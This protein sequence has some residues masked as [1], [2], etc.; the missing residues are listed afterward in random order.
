MYFE[1]ILLQLLIRMNE[2]DI[3]IP[4]E[5]S[6]LNNNKFI[7]KTAVFFEYAPVS[8]WIEDFS[9]VKQRADFIEKTHNQDIKSYISNNPEELDELANLVKIIDVN[10]AALKLYNAKSKKE[11]LTNLDKVFTKKSH[12]G[13]AKLVIDILLGKKETEIETVNKTFD[14]KEIDILIKFKV[15]DGTEKTLNHVIISVEN[16][17]ERVKI[18][19]A[20]ILSEKRYKESNEIN[21]I[22][23]W[24]YDFKTQKIHWTNEAYKLLDIELDNNDLSLDF[25]LSFVHEE[26]IHLVNNFSIQNL[27]QNPNQQLNYRIITKKGAIK[28]IFEKRSIIIEGDRIT[29]IIGIAQDITENKLAEQKLNN[30]KNLLSNALSGI[31]DGF[32]MLDFDSNYTYI[33]DKA[34]LYLGKNKSE[35]L[36]VNLWEKFPEKEGDIFY[37]NYQEALINKKPISFENYFKPWNKWFE[38]RIIPSS[39]GIMI[40]FNEITDKKHYDN[41]IK[42]AYNII[43]KSSSV[44]ILCENSYDFPIVFAS[45]NSINLFGYSYKEL[46]TNTIKLEKVVH[47]DD[48]IYFR[49]KIFEL[50]KSETSKGFKPNPFRIITKKGKIKWIKTNIDTIRNASNKITHIQGIV[51]DYTDQ[52]NKEDLFFK[53]KQQLQDQFDKTPLASIVW[54]L[55]FNVID[56]NNSAHKVFGYTA[57]EAIGKSATELIVPENI[58]NDLDIVYEKLKNLS[59]GERNTN[60]NKTKEGK[61]IICDWYN[62]P[63]KDSSGK[64]TGVAS[65]VEDITERNTSK[66]LL[67]KSEKKYRDIFEKSIDPVMILKDGILVDC[68]MSAVKMFGYNNKESLLN[69]HPSKLS[70]EKQLDGSNSYEKSEQEIKVTLDKGSNRFRWC[71]LNKEGK[72]FPVE[73]T[74]TNIDEVDSK[75][76]IHAVLKDISDR[77][78]KEELEKVL[79]NISRGASVIEDFN[80]FSFFVK[81]EL[82][83]IIDTSNFFIALHD[84][85]TDM[86]RLPVMVDAKE[87]ITDFPAKNSLTGY[88]IKNK[89]PLML[90]FAEHKKLIDKNEVELIGIAAKIWVGVPLRTQEKVFGAIVVQSYD[91]ENAYNKSDM[92][93]LEFVADQI[94]ITIQ[95]KNIEDELRRA[96]SKAQES[97]KLKSSFLANMSH[98]IR[99]PMN[100]I[101]G[102]S[103]LFI[104]PNI[105]EADRRKYAKIVINSSKQLLNIVNDIL[106]ISK[107]EAGV[108]QLHYESVHIN[109][110]LDDMY[111]FYRPIAKENN[112]TINCFKGLDNNRSIIEI[113]RQKLNQ[114]LN[115]LLSN[116]FK[117]TEIG[118]VNFGYELKEDVLE[119]Y[120]KDTG[121]GIDKELHNIIF[122]RFMQANLGLNK[123]S[124]GT[125]LGLAISKKFIELFKGEIRLESSPNGT[126]IYFTIPY[127]KAKT[128]PIITVVEQKTPQN[129]AKEM[130]LTILIAEDEEYN[131]LYITELFSSMNF[132][133][134]EAENGKRAVELADENPD[135][136]LIFMDIKMPIMNGIEAMME[137]KKQKPKL[138]IIALSAFAMESD[139]ETA[140]KNGFDEYL[141]KPIDKTKLFSLINKYAK[142]KLME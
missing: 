11:L 43:N 47:P 106:D 34:A 142:A 37:D 85:K 78:K 89:K 129:I 14:G 13:F 91:N 80:K 117:F 111:S 55:N 33:N 97:D 118:S 66:K 70:P 59:G 101:I 86:L 137:I 4:D 108:V 67:E 65:L 139:K 45:E 46:L 113:D 99:T 114:V 120:V 72:H 83:K 1:L 17:T 104:E 76:T 121:V 22:S 30:T 105:T 68:N 19:K 112:L 16:I 126:S 28:Y 18:R 103:E 134:I 40:F 73:V 87:D 10:E 7:E 53:N 5:D 141:S 135:I 61:I 77:V 123:Q 82:H 94:S 74:L 98:E 42:E 23:S 84:P 41:K 102:F 119:F 110:L 25:Y 75:F 57:Q 100:G 115:N 50:S 3:N 90:T 71:H 79:Y 136:D 8:L 138:P 95:R 21:K 26:D 52:K 131:M 140:I 69:V 132:K 51:E 58:I 20:L 116:S 133:I 63:L 109:N 122:D 48:L 29:R 6:S 130:N 62:V 24:F 44:A 60:K 88:V 127:I 15:A 93:L 81:D 56:W 32:V 124:K 49:N 27:L 96:L 35:L 107:I 38:N 2:K 54:D 128:K 39:E 64:V 9:K 12:Q 31:K 92:Q 36:G 125:G